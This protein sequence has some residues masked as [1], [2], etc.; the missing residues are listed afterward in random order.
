MGLIWRGLYQILVSCSFFQGG[1]QLLL[2]RLQRKEK[3]ENQKMRFDLEGR[4]LKQEREQADKIEIQNQLVLQYFFSLCESHDSTDQFS[5]VFLS[6]FCNI[7][8]N[9][10]IMKCLTICLGH[11]CW[12]A[13]VATPR[14]LTRYKNS[15]NTI[16][17]WFWS[18]LPESSRP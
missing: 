18:T 11:S 1:L 4:V 8:Q 14:T 10:T 7:V 5:L 6:W 12:H 15:A 2:L 16:F 17:L 3:R 13:A 9:E